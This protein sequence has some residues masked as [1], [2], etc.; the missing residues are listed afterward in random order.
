MQ[1]V[2]ARAT[3]H[4]YGNTKDGLRAGL[5]VVWV[6]AWGLKP[7]DRCEVAYDEVL[8]LI[9]ERVKGSAQAAR[10]LRAMTESK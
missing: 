9:P 10:V 2:L 1:S 5:P 8:V 3:R 6:R 4:I 7:G